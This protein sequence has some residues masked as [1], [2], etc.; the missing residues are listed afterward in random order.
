MDADGTAERQLTS[1]NGDAGM[2]RWSP[3]G[4]RIAFMQSGNGLFL[5]QTCE[6]DISSCFG[7]IRV[8]NADGSNE[9]TLARN[10]L[11]MGWSPDGKKIAFVD[12]LRTALHVV[13]ADGTN[14]TKIT[15]FGGVSSVDWSPDGS[16]IALGAAGSVYVMNADGSGLSRLTDE[17]DSLIVYRVGWSPRGDKIAFNVG[18]TVGP[19]EFHIDLNSFKIQ[20]INPDGTNRITLAADA[21]N[22]RWL[23]DGRSLSFSRLYDNGI[24][25]VAANGGEPSVMLPDVWPYDVAWSPTGDRFTFSAHTP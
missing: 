9:A 10:A 19:W 6:W 8:I 2:P 20:V 3:D 14:L 17:A 15:Q 23:L 22:P 21:L 12:G 18:L 4:G 16:R 11:L 7:E 1:A 13:N 25:I 24:W 5:S